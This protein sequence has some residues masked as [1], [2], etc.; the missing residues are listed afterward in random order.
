MQMPPEFGL[1]GC[2][3]CV[4]ERYPSVINATPIYSQ[5]T[6]D[7]DAEAENLRWTKNNFSSATT[8]G[9]FQA[10]LEDCLEKRMGWTYGPK[11][12]AKLTMFI[13]DMNM[14]E[15]NDW[16]DQPTNEIVRQ[17]QRQPM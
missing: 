17:V 1:S 11:R 5:R 13:D 16:G 6:S 2:G 4:V 10:A 8:P 14:P 3:A 9:I 15:I 12:N 7:F